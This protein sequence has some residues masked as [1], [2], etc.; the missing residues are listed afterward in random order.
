[1]KFLPFSFFLF[2]GS[3]LPSSIYIRI[4]LTKIN[5]DPCGSGSET[6]LFILVIFEDH[7]KCTD[8]KQ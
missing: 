3:V 1:M 8:G 4:Q 5:A 7:W 2:C 6:L